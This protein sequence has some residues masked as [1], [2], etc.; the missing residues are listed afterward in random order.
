MDMKLMYLPVV[1]ERGILLGADARGYC[2]S[3][4]VYNFNV[5]SSVPGH[6]INH[7]V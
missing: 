6:K 3:T 5:S 7:N 2:S 4:S 1:N